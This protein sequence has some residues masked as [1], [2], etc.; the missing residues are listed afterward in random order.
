MQYINQI[1]RIPYKSVND[2]LD[3]LNIDVVKNMN[4]GGKYLHFCRT[5]YV[6]LA[7][8]FVKKKKEKKILS[9]KW[10]SLGSFSCSPN[11]YE[12]VSHKKTEFDKEK[13]MG[14]EQ[15]S[16]QFDKNSDWSNNLSVLD[17]VRLNNV[18]RLIIYH[19]NVNSLKNKPEMLREIV[20]D[21]LVRS[22]FSLNS[23]YN[24]GF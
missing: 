13:F 10:W 24:I 2:H 21:K 4:I 5:G 22:I 1:V 8:N 3:V 11:D 23:I 15:N 6:K 9:K 12:N 18:N 17:W 19:L 7:I 20:Q 16:S 14:K